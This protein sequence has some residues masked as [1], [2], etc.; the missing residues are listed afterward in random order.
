MTYGGQR[1]F[2][3]ALRS[4]GRHMINSFVDTTWLADDKNGQPLLLNGNYNFLGS[5]QHL[6]REVN[7][8]ITSKRKLVFHSLCILLHSS[9]MLYVLRYKPPSIKCLPLMKRG[10]RGICSAAYPQE[11]ITQFCYL[12]LSFSMSFPI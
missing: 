1:T 8:V 9:N 12:Y 6:N 5:Y 7:V 3:L 2:F 4:G 10:C 11:K